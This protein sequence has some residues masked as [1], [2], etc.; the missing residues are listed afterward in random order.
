MKYQEQV[1]A[2]YD[3]VKD[4]AGRIITILPIDMDTR[5]SDT[6]LSS[7]VLRAI[8]DHCSKFGLSKNPTLRELSEIDFIK[9]GKMRGIGKKSLLELRV[10][11]SRA[12]HKK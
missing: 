4:Q 7:R 5:L 12:E 11:F 8:Q 3:R 1:F 6:D 2:E 9:F 10:L